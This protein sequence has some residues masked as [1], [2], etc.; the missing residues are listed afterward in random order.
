[1]ENC[2][3]NSIIDSVDLVKNAMLGGGGG[4]GWK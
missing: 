1:M 2:S 3:T 4:R